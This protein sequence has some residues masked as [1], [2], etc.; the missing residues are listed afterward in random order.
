MIR[1]SPEK[2]DFDIF[3]EIGEIQGFISRSNKKLSKK[4]TK[5]EVIN[6]IEKLTKMVKQLCV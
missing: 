4:S 5:N 3:D 2:E 1:I 6:D